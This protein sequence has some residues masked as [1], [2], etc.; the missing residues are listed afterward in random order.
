MTKVDLIE[1]TRMFSSRI[2]EA[3]KEVGTTNI[4]RTYNLLEDLNLFLDIVHDYI[5]ENVPDETN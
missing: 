2:K 1:D 4:L 5:Q 3:L